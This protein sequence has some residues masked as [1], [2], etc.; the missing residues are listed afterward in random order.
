MFLSRKR[1]QVIVQSRIRAIGLCGRLYGIWRAVLLLLLL[2][3]LLRCLP[4]LVDV[5][6]VVRCTRYHT[7]MLLCCRV[8][9]QG[10]RAVRHR[11]QPVFLHL[12]AAT[13]TLLLPH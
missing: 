1:Y 6:L 12:H 4:C 7:G 13:G 3:L 2:L 5:L 9:R 11:Q 8:V 10:P